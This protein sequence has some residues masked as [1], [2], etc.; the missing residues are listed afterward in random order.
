[1]KNIREVGLDTIALS[2][3][4]KGSFEIRTNYNYPIQRLTKLFM[5]PA[6][7]SLRDTEE[8]R[9]SLELSKTDGLNLSSRDD[10]MNKYLNEE[11]EGVSS[12]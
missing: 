3:V 4:K 6:Y 2:Q 7:L 10:I 8:A 9:E 1:M 11:G 12:V 5:R